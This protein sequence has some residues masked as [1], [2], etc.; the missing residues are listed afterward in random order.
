MGYAATASGSLFSF[1]FTGHGR[2]NEKKKPFSLNL[3]ACQDLRTKF[4]CHADFILI[5]I[6]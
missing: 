4:H 1:T 3:S 5:S 6:F 2:L